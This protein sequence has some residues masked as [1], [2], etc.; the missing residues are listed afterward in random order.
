MTTP[1]LVSAIASGASRH[2]SKADPDALLDDAVDIW[3]TTD[4]RVRQSRPM[5]AQ[6]RRFLEEVVQSVVKDLVSEYRSITT[7]TLSVVTE[8]LLTTLSQQYGWTEFSVYII[9]LEILSAVI[10]LRLLKAIDR[11]IDDPQQ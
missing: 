10:Y 2:L 3:A 1:D 8:R 11:R 7:V 5:P 6:L 9:P 4:A